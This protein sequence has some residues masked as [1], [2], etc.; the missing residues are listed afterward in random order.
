MSARILKGYSTLQSPEQPNRTRQ[1]SG[2]RGDAVGQPNEHQPATS[3]VITTTSSTR[4]N[5]QQEPTAAASPI[6]STIQAGSAD[7]TI[8]L[9]QFWSSTTAGLALMVVLFVVVL[10]VLVFFCYCCSRGTMHP[11]RRKNRI[12]SKNQAE[13]TGLKSPAAAVP[14]I[15]VQPQTPAW[16]SAQAPAPNTTGRSPRRL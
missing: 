2:E 7:S 6:A 4:Y 1:L 5:W 15:Q 3:D 10:P 14:A 9:E 12:K 13:L 16:Q 11:L 8:N